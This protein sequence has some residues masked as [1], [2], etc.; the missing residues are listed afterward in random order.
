MPS[1]IFCQTSCPQQLNKKY[2]NNKFITNKTVNLAYDLWDADTKLA[3]INLPSSTCCFTVDKIGNHMNV[4][5][6]G[7]ATHNN[8][9]H[10]LDWGTSM[11]MISGNYTYFDLQCF[12]T[13]M[14]RHDDPVTGELGYFHPLAFTAKLNDSDNPNWFQATRGSNSD[15]F[16]EA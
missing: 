5:Q 4:K 2:F 9:I 6:S 13:E 12:F 10:N 11:A 8:F 7:H 1:S 15:G 3:A 14:E 16:W